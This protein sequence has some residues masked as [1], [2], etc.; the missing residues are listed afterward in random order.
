MLTAL[1]LVEQAPA[2]DR[3][4]LTKP[5]HHLTVVLAAIALTVTG[6]GH[7]DKGPTVTQARD[8]L[9][10]HLSAIAVD[11]SRVASWKFGVVSRVENSFPC[12]NG[13]E[14]RQIIVA[15]AFRGKAHQTVSEML[16][17]F[18]GA[19]FVQ[20]YRSYDYEPSRGVGK[21]RDVKSRTSL[22]IV[23]PETDRVSLYGYTDCLRVK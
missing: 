4:P 8:T 22:L 16:T 23:S 13:K 15:G 21:A 14:S 6:C 17:Q 10:K 18:Y 3:M 12:A 5:L 11:Q 20:G 7:K 9:A 19:A 2:E 1:A